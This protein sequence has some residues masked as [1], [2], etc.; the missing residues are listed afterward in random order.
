MSITCISAILGLNA[1][2]PNQIKILQHFLGIK[3]DGNFGPITESAVKQWQGK[4]GL[5]KDGI[6]GP[7]TGKAMRIWCKQSNV[8]V[9]PIQKQIQD[10]TGK[11]WTTFT[12]FYNLVVKYCDYS[13]YFNDQKSLQTEIKNLIA[14]FNGKPTGNEDNC[15][16]YTQVGVA[17]AREMGYNAVPYGLYCR[18][19]QINH[20]IFLI[21]GKEFG[22]ATWID[23]A[24]AAS[25]NYSIGNHW[26]DGTPNKEP[27]WIPYE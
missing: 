27:S 11:T 9:G 4:H 22:S 25:S 3:E 15:V 1:N 5:I 18:K 26:C 12:E 10:A 21:S 16:D 2:A 13:H 6:L 17:L 8:K 20:A 23:L 19:D 7:I 14:A 24:A